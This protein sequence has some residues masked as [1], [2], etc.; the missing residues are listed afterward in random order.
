MVYGVVNIL[1]NQSGDSH[2]T[3]YVICERGFFFKYSSIISITGGVWL[4]IT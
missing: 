3:D 2:S 4:L 1:R